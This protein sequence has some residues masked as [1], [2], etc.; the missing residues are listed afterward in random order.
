MSIKNKLNKLYL[1]RCLVTKYKEYIV[2]KNPFIEITRCYKLA[3]NELPDLKNPKNL[4]EKIYWMEWNTDTSLW[5]KCTDK[6]LMRE[7]VKECGYENYLPKLFAK[8]DTSNEI[9]FTNLPK[10]FIMKTNNGCGTCYVVKNKAEEDVN[11]VKKIFKR[12]LKTNRQGYSN[13]QFHYLGIEPCIIA[14]ELL[15]NTGVQKEI[16]PNSLIDYKI[17]CF[18]GNIESIFVVYDRTNIPHGFDL[19]DTAWNRLEKYVNPTRQFE[20]RRDVNIPKPKCLDEM[21]KIASKLSE[22]FPEVRVDFYIVNDKPVIGELTF[23]TGYG[24]FTKEYYSY[25]GDK[26]DISNLKLIEK[27]ICKS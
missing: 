3:F 15:P 12:W 1:Y 10:S 17:W 19:Y 13:A 25:L 2:K 11:K 5:T 20:F 24:F 22:P 14:E 18:K 26:C 6:Y 23:S 7:Y 21:L 8:W 27:R 4:I 9:D 16:S